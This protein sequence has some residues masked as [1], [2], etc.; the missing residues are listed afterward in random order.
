M[1]PTVQT[2]QKC[3][4]CSCFFLFSALKKITTIIKKYFDPAEIC[5]TYIGNSKAKILL[6]T[7]KSDIHAQNYKCKQN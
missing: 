6:Y 1:T 3:I 2:C 5:N 4:N 7:N